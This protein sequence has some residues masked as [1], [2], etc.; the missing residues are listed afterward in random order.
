M[1]NEIWE[2]NPEWRKLDDPVKGDI[3]QLKHISAFS[4][5]VKLIV[6]SVNSD[7]ITGVVEAVFDWETK[8]P[9]TGGEILLLVNQELTFKK[10][11]MQKLIKKTRKIE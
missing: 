9:M 7:E 3:V 11:L 8:E 4:H 10:H 5:L 1:G 2:K 6:S